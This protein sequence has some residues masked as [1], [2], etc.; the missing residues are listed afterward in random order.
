MQDEE[1][2]FASPEVHMRTGWQKCLANLNKDTSEME[3]LMPPEMT[4][5]YKTPNQVQSRVVYII[6]HAGNKDC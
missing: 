2:D 4:S 1:V 5:N 3:M 6:L